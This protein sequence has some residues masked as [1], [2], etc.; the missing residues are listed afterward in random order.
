MQSKLKHFHERLDLVIN[1]LNISSEILNTSKG[2]VFE[3]HGLNNFRKAIMILDELYLL[4]EQV[5]ILTQTNVY[6]SGNDFISA[7]QSDGSSF[8][9]LN[10][11]LLEKAILIRN[12]IKQIT[13]EEKENSISIKL[14]PTKDFEEL[15]KFSKDIHIA[16]SQILYNDKIGGKAEITSVENGSIWLNVF[17]GSSAAITLIGGVVWASMVIFKKLQEGRMLEQQVRSLNI[18]NDSLK[19][20]QEKQKIALNLMIESEA[21]L[22]FDENFSIEESPEQIERLK[23]SID[24]FSKII[25]KG[26]EIHPGL[27]A[28][29]SVANLFPNPSNLIG[30]ESKINK[31]NRA[32][33]N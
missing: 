10:D 24:L 29:E 27:L 3:I 8:L 2:N 16:L 15:S 17:L 11:D 19:E 7:N 12:V 32:S 14:P 4:Q 25:E 9:R 5:N 23:N 26:A 30:L 6:K 21:K 20:I 18:K 28:P 22:L 31:L 33:E 13:P 1:L